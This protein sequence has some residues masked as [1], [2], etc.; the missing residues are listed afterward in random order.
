MTALIYS[1]SFWVTC[2]FSKIN[3]IIDD[4]KDDVVS[5]PAKTNVIN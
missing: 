5:V 2:G 4:K 3:N 1:L